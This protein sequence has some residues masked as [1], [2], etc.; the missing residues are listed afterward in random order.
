MRQLRI[1]IALTLGLISCNDN[2]N[3]T[4]DNKPLTEA[5]QIAKLEKLKLDF[6][7]PVPIDSSV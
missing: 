2:S 3:K 4:V 6:D 5:Q 1:I 7:Q